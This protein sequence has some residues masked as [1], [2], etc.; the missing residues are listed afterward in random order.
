MDSKPGRKANLRKYLPHNGKWQFF[1]VL[2]VGGRPKPELVI[3]E[4]KPRRGTAGAF[5]LDWREDGKRRTRPVGT[6]PREA[7]DAWRLHFGILAGEIE[8]PE[9]VEAPKEGSST[10]IRAAVGAYLDESSGYEGRSHVARLFNRPGV[11]SDHLQEALRGP[12][13]TIGC[14]QSF[15]GR[16]A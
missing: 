15:R 1:P 13:R 4:G 8:A 16:P 9:E 6:S 5:Y 10:T 2:K 7:L 3:I 14:H 11:V 12:A